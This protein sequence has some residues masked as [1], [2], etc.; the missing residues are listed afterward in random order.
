MAILTL[1][2]TNPKF[3]YI[4]SKNPAT[5]RDSGKPF[6]REL[7]QGQLYGWFST[8]DQ[9]FRLW[10]KDHP[11][12]SSFADGV[13]SE[14]EY[15]DMTRYASPYL[16]IQMIQTALASASKDRHEGDIPGRSLGDPCDEDMFECT[17]TVTIL[18]P[19][20]SL[21]SSLARHYGEVATVTLVDIANGFVKVAVTSP[22]VFQT[23]NI[24]QTLCILQAM[25]DKGSY[26]R[27][28]KPALE[29]YLRVL[30]NSDAP[31]F[32]RYLFA[33]RAVSDRGTFNTI[34]ERIQ[35]P[36]MTMFYGDT[37][38]QRYDAVKQQLRGG[39]RLFD[40]G[41]GEMFYALRLSKNYD[42]TYAVDADPELAVIN[43]RKLEARKVEN[44]ESVNDEVSAFWVEDHIGLVTGADF[45]LTEVLEHMSKDDAFDVLSALLH[46]DA[47][48]IVVTVPNANFNK[49]YGLEGAF[50]H[51]DHQFE[52]T[53]EDWC[54]DMVTLAA[55]YGW[56][57]DNVPIG[58]VVGDQS[59][60]TM[61]V[62]TRKENDAVI[63]T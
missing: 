21:M 26:V 38:R 35:G 33:S 29:K 24:L 5:I 4:I 36:G 31:Y 10:F 55:R 30:S 6:Q 11:T 14:F 53:F 61:S 50:R 56:C 7:R 34:R 59:V 40:I 8:D 22:T 49:H 47:R 39:E 17:A 51:D 54:D 13:L 28:D 32:V 63:G 43:S 25:Q 23:L 60:S 18:A 19:A 16:P 45:L 46:S 9:T 3:S 12:R 37:R 44:V 41:C 57:V 48:K 27:L 15:L 1:T 58:D 42:F 52:P 20:R 62:F 2:S